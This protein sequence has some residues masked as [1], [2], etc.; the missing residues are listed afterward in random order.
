MFEV[1]AHIGDC[2][3]GYPAA[4]QV[5]GKGGLGRDGVGEHLADAGFE[6]VIDQL[7]FLGADGAYHV[8]GERQV[9]LLHSPGYGPPPCRAVR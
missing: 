1:G 4:E 8:E 3:A 2:H 6:G 7:G 9:D 5:L